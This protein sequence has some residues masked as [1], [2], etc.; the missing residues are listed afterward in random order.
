VPEAPGGAEPPLKLAKVAGGQVKLTWGASC[1][2]G[3]GDYEIYSGIVGAYYTHV[4]T[5]CSTAGA[6]TW[7]LPGA[8]SSAYYLIVPA[9]GVKEGSYGTR[10]GGVERPTG[11]FACLAR[12][13]GGCP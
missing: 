8:G 7:T 11:S 10:S 2:S 9:N 1:D 13:L 5:V 4:S 3:D 12:E 6:K